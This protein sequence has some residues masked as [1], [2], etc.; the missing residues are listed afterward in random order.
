M[1]APK[2]TITDNVNINASEYPLIFWAIS[3]APFIGT[4]TINANTDLA[5][6]LGV[7]PT[8][9][10]NFFTVSPKSELEVVITDGVELEPTLPG[11]PW[12]VVLDETVITALDAEVGGFYSTL[13]AVA[14]SVPDSLIL[15]ASQSADVA[16][17]VTD[18]SN[19]TAENIALYWGVNAVDVS[20][21][22][23]A[24]GLD[25]NQ[26]LAGYTYPLS[27]SINAT[28][29][30]NS[31]LDTLYDA[32]INGVKSNFSLGKAVWGAKLVSGVD[33]NSQLVVNQVKYELTN[34]LLP[35]LLQPLDSTTDI[36]ATIDS[37]LSSIWLV[38]WLEGS[39][40][41]AFNAE[42]TLLSQPAR[43]QVDLDIRPV[44]VLE[45]INITLTVE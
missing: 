33:I 44:S 24:Y 39:F 21:H 26:P 6:T 5:T 10:A 31:E 9:L 22:I 41:D 1:V 40:Q 11:K 29:S 15:V 19:L 42:V 32:N 30:T 28:A 17:A 23:L 4:Y 2:I 13:D 25:I 37:Y 34:L 18:A 43:I 16:T 38:G 27:P 12:V 3:T 8:S 20:A 35:F 36:K 7:S 14:L 45:T